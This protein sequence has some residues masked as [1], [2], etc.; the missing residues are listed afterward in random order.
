MKE[1]PS[2]S[3]P[4]KVNGKT[5]TMKKFT[6]GLQS[7]IED[8]NIDVTLIEVLRMCTDMSE[9]DILGLDADQLEAIYIDIQAFTYTTSTK[10]EGE[11]KKP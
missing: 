11:A 4:F 8:G 3:H 6:L 10:G 1:Y 5:H 9:E 2:T 7:N